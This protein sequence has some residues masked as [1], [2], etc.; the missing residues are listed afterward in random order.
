M[1][2]EGLTREEEELFG[3]KAKE[4]QAEKE[5]LGK[6]L[7]AESEKR[8]K[9]A[10]LEAVTKQKVKYVLYGLGAEMESQLLGPGSSDGAFTGQAQLKALKKKKPDV[11]K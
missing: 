9:D 7:A 10:L 1:E 2:E 4:H 8:K 5:R 11:E 6:V 3:R